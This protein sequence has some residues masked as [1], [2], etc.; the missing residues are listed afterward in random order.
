MHF[1][2]ERHLKQLKK[3][4]LDTQLHNICDSIYQ[5][6]NAG[7]YVGCDMG[8]VH[9]QDIEPGLENI[10]AELKKTISIAN[11]QGRRG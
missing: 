4:M 9:S 2:K 1:D 10:S 3:I 8:H 6:L 5:D 7:F 11:M